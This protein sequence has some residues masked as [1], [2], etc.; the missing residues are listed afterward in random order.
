MKPQ[1]DHQKKE[2]NSLPFFVF[3]RERQGSSGGFQSVCRIGSPLPG[4]QVDIFPLPAAGTREFCRI[5]ATPADRRAAYIVS[6]GGFPKR[7]EH[8][9]GGDAPYLPAPSPQHRLDGAFPAAG[10]AG[11]RDEVIRLRR[12]YAAAGPAFECHAG[13][14]V[15]ILGQGDN[16]RMQQVQPFDE[17]FMREFQPAGTASLS[18][19]NAENQQIEK[20][21]PSFTPKNV[22][23]VF[24]F[25]LR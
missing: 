5:A 19:T 3:G 7:I 11:F 25:Y 16:I 12:P 2:G 14:A 23:S 1:R 8:L 10:R 6:G 17:P 22:K 13:L 18:A 15:D 9:P 20:Q 4:R 21:T 24:L